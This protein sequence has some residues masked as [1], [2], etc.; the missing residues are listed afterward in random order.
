MLSQVTSVKR[1]K[2][3]S[4]KDRG[5]KRLAHKKSAVGAALFSK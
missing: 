5:F 2:D 3:S 1:A 4:A